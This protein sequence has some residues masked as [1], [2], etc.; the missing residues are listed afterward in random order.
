[1]GA[2]HLG[3]KAV[4]LDRDG[5]LNH[6]WLNPLTD[7]W[8]SP[9]RPEDF[10][11]IDGTV[12]ALRALRDA[13]FL[14]FLVSNQPSAAK[15]KCSL[16]D[17]ACVHSHFRK[18]LENARIEFSAFYYSYLH[19][20]ADVPEL[21]GDRDRKPNPFFAGLAVEKFHLEPEACW[22][23]GDRDSDIEFGK[24]AGLRTVQVDSPEP[25]GNAGNARPTYKTK[26]LSQAVQFILQA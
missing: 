15:G 20:K 26:T 9:F 4:F 12:E 24:C 18:L 17:L 13:G 8:E 16:N 7:E 19:P 11:L 1:M 22:M 3:S 23:I 25:D 6:L 10:R 2:H 5:T 21:K 14:L